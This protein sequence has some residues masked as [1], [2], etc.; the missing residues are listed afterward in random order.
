MLWA[1][2]QQ[3]PLPQLLVQSTLVSG[4]QNQSHAQLVGRQT[5]CLEKTQQKCEK[6]LAQIKGS[7]EKEGMGEEGREGEREG[8]E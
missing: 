8:G 4:A 6:Q 5:D 1:P 7:L 3:Q 2:E